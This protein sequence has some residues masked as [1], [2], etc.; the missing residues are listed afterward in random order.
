[1]LLRIALFGGLSLLLARVV[2]SRPLRLL[3]RHGS[4]ELN[5]MVL[6]G[7]CL[8]CTWAGG[9]AGISEEL[10]AFLG[11]VMVSSAGAAAA[12]LSG[13]PLVLASQGRRH[14]AGAGAGVSGGGAAPSGDAGAGAATTGYGAAAAHSTYSRHHVPPNGT[15][16][17]APGAGGTTAGVKGDSLAGTGLGAMSV[18]EALEAGLGVPLLGGGGVG[19]KV[20]RANEVA[21]L[22]EELQHALR[23]N[24]DS[25]HN[26]SG[27]WGWVGSGAGARGRAH[28]EDCNTERGVRAK[29]CRLGKVGY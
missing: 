25:V 10:G 28:W 3:V 9:R 11:G 18:G 12:A 27:R 4:A 7:I 17:A 14:G 15:G 19:A 23:H 29:L 24:I 16:A 20:E 21:R 22:A 1:M 6:V 8:A 13:P 2:L 5:Q 26:V